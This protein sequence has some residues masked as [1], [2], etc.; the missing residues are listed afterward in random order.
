MKTK[1]K[2]SKQMSRRWCGQVVRRVM[3]RY[4]LFLPRG[5]RE[6]KHRRWPLILFL[7]GMG[8]RGRD[9]RKVKVHGPLAYAEAAA[10]FPFVVVAPQCSERE[11]WS[12]E[13][14]NGLL[15]TVL[16][17]EAIDVGRVYLTGLSMGGFGAWNLAM[18]CPERFAAIAPIC[19]GGNPFAPQAMDRR[20]AQALRTLGIWAFHGARDNLVPLEETERM[21]R[22]FRAFGCAEVQCT[23]YPEAEHDS[24]T[25]TYANPALYAWFLAHARTSGRLVAR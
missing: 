14:L 17:R 15:D 22:A 24:W 9:I 3:V 4:W 19:G 1:V 16:D 13:A 18:E 12:M 8:E 11:W 6:D 10:D 23:V 7:H 5:Y 21:V 2:E 25:T 20:R